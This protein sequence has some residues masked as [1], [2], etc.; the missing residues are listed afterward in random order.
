MSAEPRSRALP[1]RAQVRIVAIG[2]LAIAVAIGLARLIPAI[3]GSRPPAEAPPP[4]PGYFRPTPDQ[5]TSLTTATIRVRSFVPTVETDGKIATDDDATTPVFSPFSGHVTQV[6]AKAGEWVAAG[7]PLFAIDASEFVQAQNDLVTAAAG[8]Q[9]ARQQLALALTNEKREAALYSAQGG[10][11]KDLQQSRVDLASAQGAY[12]TAEIA[13]TAVRSRLR[14]LGQTEPQI[15]AMIRSGQPS[16][17]SPRA[18]VTAP[19]AGV[20]LQRQVG[21]GQNIVSEASGGATPEFTLADTSKVWLLGYVREG[22][23]PAM[24]PG[25]AVEA[26]PVAFPGRVFR[27]RLDYVAGSLDPATHLLFVHAEI[28]NPDGALKPEMFAN[29]RILTGP[30]RRSPAVSAESVIY[31]GPEARVWIVGPDRTL[32]LRR[33]EPG[34][35]EAGFV[36]ALSGVAAGDSVVVSG[37][38]FIDRAAT[39]SAE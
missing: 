24:R 20:I 13:L 21:P 25:E 12:R 30:A 16:T 5:W 38:L 39:A 6:F 28:D 19:I 36:E 22:D 10:A 32:A 17:W 18:V 23:A 31:E 35:T 14:I 15:D 37:S 4:P 11:L 34:R 7:S 3:F 8:L 27:G 2:V 26:R 33:I 29:I 9:T 1:A